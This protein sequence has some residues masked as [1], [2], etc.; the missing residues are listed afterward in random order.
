MMRVLLGI[1]LVSALSTGCASRPTASNRVSDPSMLSSNRA[2][3]R[4]PLGRATLDFRITIHIDATGRPDL[5][6]LEITGLGAMDN[7]EVAVAWL[8]SAR[9]RPAQ[10]A[11]QAV[12]GIF[13]TRVQA[14][15]QVR[16][17]GATGGIDEHRAASPSAL[18]LT[19]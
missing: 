16:R 12:E 3:W 8:Q 9:F 17:V 7:R 6:T 19:A 15:A 5:E 14:R 1:A 11:S 18:L 13:R 2:D 10:R 4:L